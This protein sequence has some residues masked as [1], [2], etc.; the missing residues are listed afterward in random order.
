MGFSTSVLLVDDD[1]VL[2]QALAE[3]FLSLGGFRVLQASTQAA[4]LNTVLQEQVDIILLDEAL[5]DTDTGSVCALMRARGIRAPILILSGRGSERD[6]RFALDAGAS[7]HI[8]KPFF[9]LALLTRIRALVRS[10]E[11][12]EA[13]QFRIGPYQFYPTLKLLLADPERRIR[14]TE[15]ET[16][17]LRYLYRARGK[18][19]GR[20]ELLSQVWG[21]HAA[22]TTHTLETH[23]Y[24]LRQKIE[25]DPAVACL[26]LTEA[27]GYRLVP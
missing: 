4:G 6:P 15:K 25:P 26:L 22:V 7:D 12:S 21:Y 13:A 10:F 14:L 19:V 16:S 5:P 8:Q 24:R 17:M 18:A 27:G 23:V 11:Q 1:D 9:F 20:D 2:R 3:Q